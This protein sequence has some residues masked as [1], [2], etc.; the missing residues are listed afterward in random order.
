MASRWSTTIDNEHQAVIAIN[1]TGD[2]TNI[3]VP[4]LFGLMLISAAR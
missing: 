2:T 4:S 3:P 1:G